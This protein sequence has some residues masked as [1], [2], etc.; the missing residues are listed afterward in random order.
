MANIQS[1]QKLSKEDLFSLLST[2]EVYEFY[3]I[4]NQ[5]IPPIDHRDIPASF[6]FQLSLVKTNSPILIG[7]YDHSDEDISTFQSCLSQGYSYCAYSGDKLIGLIVAEKRSWNNTLWVW[8]F[9]VHKDWRRNGI[10]SMLM[11]KLKEQAKNSS[12]SLIICETQGKNVP[13]IRF[14]LK[15]GFRLDGLDVSYYGDDGLENQNVAIFM[16]YRIQYG[17]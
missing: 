4:T 3:Q 1:L 11:E 10:G 17:T 13:A 8:E 14:Y 5:I 2:Q 6:S 7:E 12:I 16:K 9:C 15:Q